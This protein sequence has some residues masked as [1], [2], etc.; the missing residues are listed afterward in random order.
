MRAFR[1]FLG[2]SDMMAYLA[3]VAKSSSTTGLRLPFESSDVERSVL[4]SA[5]ECLVLEF[6]GVTPERDPRHILGRWLPSY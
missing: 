5:G 2:H 6:D 3:M 4:I 1:T